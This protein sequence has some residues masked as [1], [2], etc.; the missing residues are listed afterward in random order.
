MRTLWRWIR[1]RLHLWKID[2]FVIVS[3]WILRSRFIM[4]LFRRFPRLAR[5]PSGRLIVHHDDVKQALHQGRSFGVPYLAKMNELGGYF[6]LGLDEGPEHDILRAAVKDALTGCDLEALHAESRGRA[7]ELLGGRSHIEVVGDLTDPVLESTIGRHLWS[8]EVTRSQLNDSRTVFRDIFINSLKD[9]RVSRQ[10][11]VAADR[12]RD[13]VTA[14]VGEHLD[15]GPKGR[16]H[17]PS[18]GRTAGSTPRRSSIRGSGC[19]WP[20]QPPSRAGRRSP[21][22]P[23]SS[24]RTASSSR[25][26]RRATPTATR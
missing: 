11:L 16:R 17:R 8:G 9:P 15:R 7:E 3:R 5:L 19:W 22:T 10:A 24:S 21:W 12:L 26:P 1:D 23:C 13:H 6:V 2:V 18:A 25:R 20:G 14:V 4:A